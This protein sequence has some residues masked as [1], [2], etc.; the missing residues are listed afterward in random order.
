VALENTRLFE[1]AQLRADEQAILNEL[2]QALAMSQEIDNVMDAA[3]RHVSRLVD[4]KNFYVALHD[5]EWDEIVVPYRV[6]DGVVERPYNARPAGQGGLTEYL[7]EKRQPLLLSGDIAEQVEAL[8]IASLPLRKG[9]Q[10]RSWLGVPLNLGDQCLGIMVL[11]DYATE[12]AF[13]ARHQDLLVAV[14]NQLAITLQNVR[15]LEESQ[16]RAEEQSALNEIGQALAASQDVDEV[17]ERA[18]R[19]VRELLGATSFYMT[20]YDAVR[21]EMSLGLQA[22]EGEVS[23]LSGSTSIARGGLTDH[24]LRIRQPLLLPDRVQERVTEMGFELIPLQSRGMSVSWVGVP[25]LIG[26]QV[27]GTM[28][29]LSYSRPRAFDLRSQEL[30]VALANHVALSLQNVRLLEET[31]AA[32][33]EVEE[34]HRSYLRR[35]WQ[36]HLRQRNILEQGGFVFDRSQPERAE[37]VEPV[38]ALWRPEMDLALDRRGAGA[39]VDGEAERT[40]LAIP[41]SLR[42]QTLGVLGVEAVDGERQWTDDDVALIEAIAEQ[43]AQTLE[44]ARLFAD[45]QRRAERERLIGEITAKI[46]TSTDI[47][48]ILETTATELGR[49]LG[50]SRALVHLGFEQDSTPRIDTGDSAKEEG[51]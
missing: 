16:S 37:S 39:A 29:A 6:L 45:T 3:Y 31:R 17:M 19:G 51:G 8:G 32:L 7:M 46:R 28:V 1:E 24:L 9:R 5:V 33:A 42:G 22:V 13:D 34:T 48:D 2:G 12:N 14:G 25:I 26:D 18:Y 44:S 15:L 27:L 40:G 10:S 50:T 36:E 41:I 35:G 47:Q 21:D 4:V 23:R 11:L 30:L 20:L 43:L 49:A 38:P